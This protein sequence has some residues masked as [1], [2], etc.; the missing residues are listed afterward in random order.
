MAQH[1]QAKGKLCFKDALKFCP[2]GF[3]WSYKSGELTAWMA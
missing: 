1:F 2:K 3:A